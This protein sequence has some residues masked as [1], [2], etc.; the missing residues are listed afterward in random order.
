RITGAELR[1]VIESRP[2]RTTVEREIREFVEVLQNCLTVRCDEAGRNYVAGEASALVTD[3]RLNFIGSRS[4]LAFDQV[5]KRNPRVSDKS[6]FAV[7]VFGVAEIA[8]DFTRRRH[9]RLAR[10]RRQQLLLPLLRE[11][12]EEAFFQVFAAD[13]RRPDRAADVVAL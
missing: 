11:E 3:V 9:A 6:L 2:V 7:A 8:Q 4:R 13:L 1:L 12:E 10:R 5:G